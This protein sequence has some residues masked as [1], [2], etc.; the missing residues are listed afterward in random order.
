VNSIIEEVSRGSKVSRV[1]SEDE[2]ASYLYTSGLPDPDMIVRTGGE[3]R[4]SGFLPW[5]VVYS[6]LYFTDVFWPDFNEVEF[7]RAIEE[8]GN[9][10][11]RFGK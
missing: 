7:E 6:E 1:I 2:F 5:Q 10:E 11:R 9:R 4:L 8:F 3:T